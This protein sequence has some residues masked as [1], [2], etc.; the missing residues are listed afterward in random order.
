MTQRKTIFQQLPLAA[1]RSPAARAIAILAVDGIKVSD[2]LRELLSQCEARTMT[3][4]EARKEVIARAL[5]MAA[6][7]NVN[8]D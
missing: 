6:A 2:R 1:S 5:A 4:D 7:K 3:Y 8:R